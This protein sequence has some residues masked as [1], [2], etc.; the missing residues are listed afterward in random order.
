M[1]HVMRCFKRR[2]AERAA[3]ARERNKAAQGR[4][5][6]SWLAETEAKNDF[7]SAVALTTMGV[8]KGLQKGKPDALR[9]LMVQ[10]K[11]AAAEAAAEA[12]EAAAE[13]KEAAQEEKADLDAEAALCAV[14]KAAREAVERDDRPRTFELITMYVLALD[15]V[16]AALFLR[17]RLPSEV[18][19]DLN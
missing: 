15:W 4:R 16:R 14:E 2:R 1:Y 9:Q 12:T 11:E 7:S 5:E 13:K 19:L 18:L 6:A 8:S 3:I 17:P 10:A